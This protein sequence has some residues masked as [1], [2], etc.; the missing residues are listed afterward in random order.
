MYLWG[1]ALAEVRLA[2]G[3]AREAFDV[4]QR[5]KARTFTERMGGGRA[6]PVT[7]A[8]LRTRVLRPGEVVFDAFPGLDSLLV[9]VVSRDELRAYT[10]PD[11]GAFGARW[12]EAG[13]AGR[14]AE[15]AAGT[16][17]IRRARTVARTARPARRRR[18][19]R[20][21][22]AG[23]DGDGVSRAALGDLLPVPGSTRTL[24]GSRRGGERA[25]AD[26][27]RAV[28]NAR[29]ASCRPGRGRSCSPGITGPDGRE[30]SGAR[31]EAAEFLR[32]RY[33]S[34]EVRAADGA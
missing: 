15:D 19:R 31:E 23:R 14:T 12:R 24:G 33:A 2:G 25:V 8:T 13:S 18:G 17:R 7:L 26:G 22:P 34:A 28:A 3:G 11:R 30:L 5:L 27:A 20:R 21:A 29:A 10:V 4:A 32:M 9:F 1:S 6:A 16:A